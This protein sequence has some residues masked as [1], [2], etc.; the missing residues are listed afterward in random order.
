MGLAV[1]R[2][3]MKM[4]A[5]SVRAA[6]VGCVVWALAVATAAT[7]AGEAAKIHVV[8]FALF[9]D[10]DVFV[11]EA[12]KAARIVHEKFGRGGQVIVQANTPRKGNAM[13]A[14]LR[15]A[16]AQVAAKMDR[17][18]DVIFLFV[19]SH[20]TR[21]GV[22]VK[23]GATTEVL[24]PP[25]LAEML[26][27]TGI[28]RRILV[29]SACFS[30]VFAD[31]LADPATL[32][33]TAASAHRASFGC[34]NGADW[35]YFGK[36]FFADAMPRT[37]TFKDA[38]MLASKLVAEREA[39]QR[40]AHSRPMMAGGEHVLARLSQGG[41]PDGAKPAKTARTSESLRGTCTFK[42][43]AAANGC[44]VFSGYSNGRRV[45]YFKA[46]RGKRQVGVAA[47]GTCPNA[48]VPGKLVASNK[49]RADGSVYTFAPDCRSSVKTTQ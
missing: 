12:E 46:H 2:L 18:N 1:F 22:F 31:A 3:D 45:G 7:A 44:R 30:G 36:A 15:S 37:Q 38:F 24:S 32:V 11:K 49:I 16:L 42:V 28:R 6:I 48:F 41:A 20:G 47:G 10:Q 9:S 25:D 39:A 21:S 26:A 40:L 17:D 19:T 33:I 43:E 35:T 27:Q 13:I 14:D 4:Q 8:A 34:R 29:I 23:A 5:R